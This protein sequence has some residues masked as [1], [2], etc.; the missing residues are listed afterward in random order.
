MEEVHDLCGSHDEADT[1]VAFHAVN[2][3]QLNLGNTVIKCNDT[4]SSL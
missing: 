4:E 3:E 2:V 1:P